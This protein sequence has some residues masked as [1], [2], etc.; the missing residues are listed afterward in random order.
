MMHRINIQCEPCKNEYCLE[1]FFT[2]KIK[3]IEALRFLFI[4]SIIACHLN[5]GITNVIDNPIYKNFCAFT[6]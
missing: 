5:Q 3:N 1:H 2:Q 4:L 6:H